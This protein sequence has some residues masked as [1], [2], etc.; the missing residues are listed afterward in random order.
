[1]INNIFSGKS[2]QAI[3]QSKEVNEKMIKPDKKL[4]CRV[5]LLRKN[6]KNERLSKILLYFYRRLKPTA[7]DKAMMWQAAFSMPY[8]LPIA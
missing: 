1:M 2:N 6:K 3:C 5:R 4:L 7:M 8:P